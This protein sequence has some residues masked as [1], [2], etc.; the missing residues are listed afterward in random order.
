RRLGQREGVRAKVLVEE[1]PHLPGAEPDPP[2]QPLDATLVERSVE[3]QPQR[4]R[5]HRREGTPDRR[6]RRALGMAAQARTK[7]GA[8]GRRHRGEEANVLAPSRARRRADDA[9]VDAGCDDP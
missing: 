9:A 6:A 8:L 3:Y 5:D 1:P 4:A 2:R 7:T